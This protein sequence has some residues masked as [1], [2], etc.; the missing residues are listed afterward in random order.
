MPEIA[1]SLDLDFCETETLP[2]KAQTGIAKRAETLP[3]RA[4]RKPEELPEKWRNKARQKLDFVRMAL[5]VRAEQRVGLEQACEMVAAARAEFFPNLLSGGKGGASQLTYH[6]CRNW[7]KLLGRNRR[8]EVNLDN[9]SGLVDNYQTGNDA[10]PGDPVFWEF[11]FARFLNPVK[12]F[13]SE[14][15]RQA[16]AL[17]REKNPFAVIPSEQQCRYQVRKLDPAVVILARE[18][19]E[20]CKNKCV[21]FIRRDWSDVKPGMMLVADHRQFDAAIQVPDE[22]KN[23]PRAVRPYICAM[24]DAASW[25][26]V[27]WVITADAPNSAIIQD[28]L[29]MAIV[30]NDM[31]PPPFILRD[32]GADFKAK[33]FGTPVE[34][35][36]NQF[37]ILRSLGTQPIT[38][39]AYNAKPKP[40]ERV[41]QDVATK[42]DK[43]FASYLGNKPGARPDAAQFYWDN[44]QYL[45]TVQQFSELWAGWLE[46]YHQTPKEGKIAG[47]KCPREL[48][49]ARSLESAPW[50]PEALKFAFLKPLPQ[51]RTV[52]RGPCVQI[53][54]KEYYGDALTTGLK[55][56]VKTDRN[57]S[58][59]VWAF[60]SAGRLICECRTRAMIKAIALGDETAR[61]ELSARMARS[62]RQLKNIR[63]QIFD[64]TKGKHLVDGI[65]LALSVLPAAEM[66]PVKLGEAAS[67]KGASHKFKHYALPNPEE[68]RETAEPPAEQGRLERKKTETLE[69]EAKLDRVLLGKNREDGDA[70]PLEINLTQET[71]N[72]DGKQNGDNGESGAEPELKESWY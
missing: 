39:Q 30:N 1:L 47:G 71:P 2:V 21:D 69:F 56:M 29:W 26:V 4:E 41:F 6:N 37:S 62:R 18:G 68:P 19:E 20:A 50:S 25:S 55:V 17:T 61:E 42:F 40:V 7:I 31:R 38:C 10:K 67:V 24:M 57:D 52:G 28:A 13:I 58:E 5:T 35:D 36:G 48:W 66:T 23:A 49:E 34:F 11:F 43:Y 3:A 22:E 9:L 12:N 8:G 70:E 60:D 45:P 14:S 32:N 46:I 64:L 63:T 65:E 33:G 59:R 27:G 54:N 16:A 51:L 44:P 53:D 72:G 15:H